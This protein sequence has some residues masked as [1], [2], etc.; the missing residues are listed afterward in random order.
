MSIEFPFFE[1]PQ[2]SRL[3]LWQDGYEAYQ[4][5]KSVT[6]QKTTISRNTADLRK[7]FME[8]RKLP[9]QI[10][11]EDIE[12]TMEVLR[13]KGSAEHSI[14]R[15]L[16]QVW[17]LFEFCQ[18]KGVDA[19]YPRGFNPARGVER[20]R[21]KPYGKAVVLSTIEVQ[22]LLEVMR[23]EAAIVS[24]RDYAFTLT[25]LLLGDTTPYLLRMKWGSLTFRKYDTWFSYQKGGE[26]IKRQ[27]PESAWQAIRHYLEVSGRLPHIQ[28]HEYIFAPLAHPLT[29]GATGQSQ[30]WDG[31]RF[32]P[33]TNIWTNLKKFARQ[34][35]IA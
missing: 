30:D 34:A 5:E 10:T 18:K 11:V 29:E 20:V 27:V 22:A 25:R 15:I 33:A 24:R 2:S 1:A 21:V 7:F 3:K 16:S 35:G 17:G 31:S 26:H 23:S 9:W 6:C 13:R 4:R 32:L 14:N 8:V 28:P 19:E 12:R